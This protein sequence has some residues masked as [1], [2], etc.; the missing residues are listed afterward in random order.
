MEALA[1]AVGVASA[2]A[3][4]AVLAAAAAAVASVEVAAAV[5]AAEDAAAASAAVT[6]PAPEKNETEGHLLADGPLFLERAAKLPLIW[7]KTDFLTE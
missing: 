4:S 3:A 5:S 6:E 2:A 1:A 7:Y